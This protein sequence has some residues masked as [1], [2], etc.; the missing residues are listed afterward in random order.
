MVK[1]KKHPILG[2]MIRSDGLVLLPTGTSKTKEHWTYGADANG[3]KLIMFKGKSYRV[4]R[5]VAE[6]FI[7]NSE[8]KPQIDHIDRDPSNNDVE[9]LRWVTA[10]ENS[11]NR[12]TTAKIGCRSIDFKSEKEYK[13]YRWNKWHEKKKG[14]KNV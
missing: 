13:T 6:T 11:L 3:Y 2:I 8:N 9:N 5:L 14:L 4:H 12:K 10:Q 1:M 7:P